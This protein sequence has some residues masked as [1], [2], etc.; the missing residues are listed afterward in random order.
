[1]KD[2]NTRIVGTW[3]R[4]RREITFSVK[5]AKEE[6]YKTSLSITG[7]TTLTVYQTEPNKNILLLGTMHHEIII[8]STSNRK[9][10]TVLFYNT[11]NY[12]VY[13]VESMS[14]KYTV[15]VASRRWSIHRFYILSDLATINAWVIHKIINDSK[16]ERND[17]L[18][19]LGE[20]LGSHYTNN[21]NKAIPMEIP[22]KQKQRYKVSGQ[23]ERLKKEF[24]KIVSNKWTGKECYLC[25]IC[26]S[27]S[28]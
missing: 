17:F 14:R 28:G 21:R 15:K 23:V 5:I 24:K 27:G 22:E 20:E 11:T 19:Q 9:P 12:G 16:I 6:S 10:K 18:L 8:S 13:V 7:D 4:V 2:R 25:N 26:Y 1:M 3:N